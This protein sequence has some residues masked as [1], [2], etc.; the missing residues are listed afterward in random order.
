MQVR[1]NCL[2]IV[3]ATALSS[4]LIALTLSRVGIPGVRVSLAFFVLDWSLLV[5]LLGSLHFGP[6]LYRTQLQLWRRP[7]KRVAI[8][9]AGDAGMT[10]V[11]ESRVGSLFKMPAR[12]HLR[13]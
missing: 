3:K 1:T 8:V 5:L 13:R 4:G 11:R 10:L 12:G 6:R 2:E 7:I 9:G